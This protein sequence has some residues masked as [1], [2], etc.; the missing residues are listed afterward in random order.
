V[1]SRFLFSTENLT[2]LPMPIP[3][4]RKKQLVTAVTAVAR[5]RARA[6]RAWFT[7]EHLRAATGWLFLGTIL[8]V[9]VGAISSAIL[10]AWLS[11]TLPDPNN[12]RTRHVA[13]STKI[14]DR[15][16]KELLYEI[17][18]EEKR[19]VVELSAIPDRVQQA[20]IAIEDKKFYEHSGFRIT[21]LIRA[22]LANVLQGRKAQGGSTITQ[23]LV[24][25]AIL[26]NQKSFARKIKELFLSYEIER[27]FSKEEILKLYFN[28]IPYGSNAYGVEA[29][30]QTFLGKSARD[31]DLV[32]AALLAAL[33]NAP[34]YYSPY[35]SHTENLITRVHLVLDRMHEEGYITKEE[36]D[37]AKAE[38]PLVRVVKKSNQ[39]TKA[40]HFVIMV[41]EQL[42]EKYGE[43]M[44]EQGGLRVI[45][46]LDWQKQQNAE[47]AVADNF[48][49]VQ[50]FG[51][52]N[53]A[54]V[55]V[56][57]KTGEVLAL[58]GS[59]D[60]YD[61]EHSGNTNI[62]TRPRQPGSSF[63]PIVY[64]A[65]FEKGYTPNTVL[66]DVD[67]VFEHGG[68]PYHPRNYDLNQH[69]PVTVRTALAGSL[70]IPA[71]KMMYL[72]GVGTVI[73]FAERLGY[74]TFTDRSRLGLAIVLGGAEV[75]PLEHAA[76]FASFAADG[77]HRAPHALL[78]VEDVDGKV[79]D[80]WK[81]EEGTRVMDP[82]IAR[83]ITSIMS[84][85]AARSFIFGAQNFLTL[86]DR[87]VA[88]KTGT[89]NEFRDAWTVGFTPSLATVVW[90]GNNDNKAMHKG[91]DGSQIAA[92]IWN[93]FM[94]ESLKGTPVE[95]FPAPKPIVTGKPVLDGQTTT[96]TVIKIDRATGMLATENTPASFIE[97]HRISSAHT[98][99]T[100]VN[101]DDPRG[102]APE[103]PEVDPEY[104]GWEAAIQAWAKEN[105]TST[106]QET[107][108]P[109]TEKDAVHI[110][111]N[112]PIIS[113]TA[114]QSNSSI[115]S[116][117][118]TVSASASAPRGVRRVEYLVDDVLIGV[119]AT[120]PWLGTFSLPSA[121]GV[122]FHTLEARAYDD[123]D[124]RGT[125]KIQINV[126]VQGQVEPTLFWAAPS[127]GAVLPRAQFP[128]TLSASIND[129]SNI[130]RLDFVAVSADQSY[131]STVGSI[132]NPGTNILL[133]KWQLA[134]SSGAYYLHIELQRNDG[135]T[136]ISPEQIAVTVQ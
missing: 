30:S 32:E 47:K 130:A 15:E 80:E 24:K 27:R 98:I 61:K 84:D 4:L 83:N 50:D 42:A 52:S 1:Y 99:L 111:E 11:R 60:Y 44:V 57:P 26:T 39:F 63:K 10:F 76:A 48:K 78:R 135:T 118:V 123:V 18:G 53:A 105:V 77:I 91:A 90:T 129:A 59:H 107:F 21:S 17:H 55:A 132:E 134:P 51:G 127:Q 106:P 8:L 100:Y 92:P 16:G 69:G 29:A 115:D 33:P 67:T 110:P 54:L 40:Q 86:R 101:K 117:F 2:P 109:P 34:S 136:H 94:R 22:V 20:T 131:R 126:T 104:A 28:E 36:T 113:F 120:E 122:G 124:N 75:K 128:V 82:E 7:R 12:I 125:A 35:G 97:E 62:I 13:Q 14:F 46:T 119:T 58:V 88:A 56:D 74:S 79:L 9:V 102:P 68:Q 37:A 45:T 31:A 108:T 19:T 103:N 41:K 81:P 70:N 73:D 121:I 65:S 93:Q 66:Y 87:P 6:F 72:T 49:R 95:T 3:Q 96:D 133:T 38:D 114:P 64:A 23:Q 85:N 71:V 25:N 112:A 89:T 116:R 5:R 43:E